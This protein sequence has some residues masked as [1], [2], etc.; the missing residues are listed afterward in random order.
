MIIEL[1]KEQVE[2]L[3]RLVETALQEIGPEIHHTATRDY[4]DFLKARKQVL[5]RLYEQLSAF[6]AEREEGGTPIA[7]GL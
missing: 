7:A 6:A 3:T 1:T 4:R 2:E 5:E